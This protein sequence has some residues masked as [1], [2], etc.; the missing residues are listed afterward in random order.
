MSS[1]LAVVAVVLLYACS[2]SQPSNFSLTRAS[3]DATYWCPGGSHDAAYDVHATIDAR[4]NTPSAVSIESATASMTLE[5]VTGNW[6]EKV[7]DRY[8]ASKVTFDPS[9]VAAGETVHIKITFSSACTSG[10]YNAGKTSQGDYRV[11][12]RLTT[13]AG[14][15][16]IAASN[17]HSIL[18]A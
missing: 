16:S 13:S 7:G 3:V 9:S 17:P 6:L 15:Y 8:E 12:M 5:S 14:S 2:S 10:Q 4:N 1:R 11:M 18:A